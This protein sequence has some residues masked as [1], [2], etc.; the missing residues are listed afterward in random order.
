M[1]TATS[2][3]FFARHVVGKWM[4][5][6]VNHAWRLLQ[7]GN[8]TALVTTRAIKSSTFVKQNHT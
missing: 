3:L 7:S 4:A 1:P 6:A 2:I 5:V 8:M